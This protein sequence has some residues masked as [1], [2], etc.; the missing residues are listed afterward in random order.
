M[1]MTITLA[2]VMIVSGTVFI[3]A[4]GDNRDYRELQNATSMLQADLRYAQRR[5]ISEGRR[6]GVWIDERTGTFYHIW[7]SDQP[8]DEPF[9]TVHLSGGVEVYAVRGLNHSVG[10][11]GTAWGRVMYTPRGTLGGRA[12]TIYLRNGRHTQWITIN[13]AGG[14]AQYFE[15]ERDYI[16]IPRPSPPP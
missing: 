11:G 12:G 1:E 5:A 2:V 8:V 3:Y 7:A 15:I 9:R 14:R 4:R 13:V 16:L 6:I 10:S